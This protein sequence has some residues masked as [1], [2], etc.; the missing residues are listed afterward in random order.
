MYQLFFLLFLLYLNLFKSINF[1]I[2]DIDLMDSLNSEITGSNQTF[3][4][5]GK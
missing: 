3:T 5:D 1:F 2:K 4:S